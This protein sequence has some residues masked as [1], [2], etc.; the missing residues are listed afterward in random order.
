M[1]N[2]VLAP[3]VPE[4]SASSVLSGP[5]RATVTIPSRLGGRAEEQ[6]IIRVS[7]MGL[8]GVNVVLVSGIGA[9]G[10]R[11]RGYVCV[12]WKKEMSYELLT[13]S[14]WMLVPLGEMQLYGPLSSVDKGLNVSLLTDLPL[15]SWNTSD[16]LTLPVV[17]LMATL[18]GPIQMMSELARED[19]L[20]TQS[21]V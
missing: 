18:S 12:R 1:L 3:S 16:T 14:V 4:F 19:V 8:G 11:E 21:R 7:S 13:V 2:I 15:L 9:V 17:A 5:S 6:S 10:V 20:T